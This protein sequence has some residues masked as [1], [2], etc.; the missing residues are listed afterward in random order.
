MQ[1]RRP[2]AYAK[3]GGGQPPGGALRPVVGVMGS[4][5]VEHGELAE[6]LGRFL[7][8]EGVHLLTGGGGGV[9]ASVSG[10]FYHVSGRAGLV[11]GILPGRTGADGRHAPLPGYP[12]RWVEIAVVTHLDRRG[13]AGSD[14]LSRNHLNVLSSH[15]IVA[16]PGGA[17]TRSEVE[18]ALRYGRPVV[19]FL[20]DSGTIVDLDRRR[21]EVAADMAHVKRFVREALRKRA[22]DRSE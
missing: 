11:L 2:E 3:G 1:T 20:G 15:V 6:P 14:P 13:D 12:N 22:A 8:L 16:L 5:R 7:A 19:A 4:G 18:L 21:V 9:M 17:G 10:A